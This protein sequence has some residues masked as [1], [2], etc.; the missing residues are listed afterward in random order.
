MVGCLPVEVWS[1]CSQD[2]LLPHV[3]PLGCL[4]FQV[5][6]MTCFFT[7][8]GTILGLGWRNAEQIVRVE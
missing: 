3:L 7:Q 6:T 1:S 5:G 4:L 8:T 2:P